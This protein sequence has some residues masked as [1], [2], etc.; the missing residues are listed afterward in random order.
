MEAALL[1]FSNWLFSLIVWSI[2]SPQI[3]VQSNKSEQLWSIIEWKFWCYLSCS[4]QSLGYQT[5]CVTSLWILLKLLPC[6]QKPCREDYQIVRDI[7]W[8]FN[9][10]AD[11]LAKW[12]LRCSSKKKKKK[13]KKKRALRCNVNDFL[14]EEFPPGG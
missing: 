1:K 8:D 3:F 9:V 4:S 6:Q 14:P 11:C 10:V 2:L 13:K 5:S 12:P 7:R